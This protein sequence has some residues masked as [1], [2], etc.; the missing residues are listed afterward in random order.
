[1]SDERIPSEAEYRAKLSE[2]KHMLFV[3]NG[4][5]HVTY[6]DPALGDVE[7]PVAMWHDDD[8]QRVGPTIG[9]E[10]K[11]IEIALPNGTYIRIGRAD[12]K[13]IFGMI[14]DIV[15][16]RNSAEF[17]FSDEEFQRQENALRALIK[18]NVDQETWDTT[19]GDD[20]SKFP[21]NPIKAIS[22]MNDLMAK[23]VIPTDPRMLLSQ[24]LAGKTAS[25]DSASTGLYL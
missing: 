21:L 9:V 17:S 19:F 14:G 2:V 22:V 8:I 6:H 1:M 10:F 7:V 11:G 16:A 18:E 24:R 15:Q 13:G 23:G 5:P 25:N 3:S 20:E 12:L 4:R